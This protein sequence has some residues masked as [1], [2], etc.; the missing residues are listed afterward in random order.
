MNQKTPVW[1]ICAPFPKSGATTF[2]R[3]LVDYYHFTGRNVALF[4]TDLRNRALE[5]RFPDITQSVDLSTTSGQIALFDQLIQEGP[6]PRI[7][8]VSAQVHPLFVSQARNNG[9]FEEAKNHGLDASI[10]FISNGTRK[11]IEAGMMVQ[12]VW[13]LVPVIPV[14]NEGFVRIGS[15]LNDHLDSFPVRRS[16]QVPLMEPLL[17]DITDGPRFSFADFMR[18]PPGTDAMSLVL[19]ADLRNWIERMFTQLR[20]HELRRA[21][22]LSEFILK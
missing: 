4:E 18:A 21:F 6:M 10:L 8:E 16:F 7:V 11:A 15:K 3:L 5:T 9:F 13:R 17:R 2:T 22:E 12:S 19:R 20:S 14:V 1:V